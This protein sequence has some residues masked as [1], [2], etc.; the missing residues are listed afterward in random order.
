MCCRRCQSK[1]AIRM[2]YILAENAFVVPVAKSLRPVSLYPFEY[3][4]A[5]QNFGLQL[6]HERF[7][8]GCG[9]LGSDGRKRSADCGLSGV[10]AAA[11]GRSVVI[12]RRP[13]L[14]RAPPPSSILLR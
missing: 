2:T 1:A 13:D 7:P 12:M 8:A 14:L 10:K 4:D 6:F 9:S 11:R 3:F 5:S